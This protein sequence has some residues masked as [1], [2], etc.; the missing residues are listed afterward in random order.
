MPVLAG[1]EEVEDAK[2][3]GFSI[4]T[5]QR[6]LRLQKLQPWEP[7]SRLRFVF[8]EVHVTAPVSAPCRHSLQNLLGEGATTKRNLKRSSARHTGET[9]ELKEEDHRATISDLNSADLGRGSSSWRASARCSSLW[10]CAGRG[11]AARRKYEV[12]D[13]TADDEVEKNEDVHDD[14]ATA[15]FSDGDDDDDDGN[16][17]ADVPQDGQATPHSDAA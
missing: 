15:E 6:V 4:R 17:D 2:Q 12:D 13:D 3:L 1:E 16:L 8:C 10:R 11:A 14:N 7:G 9:F 5:N